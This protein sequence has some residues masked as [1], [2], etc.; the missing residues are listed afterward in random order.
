MATPPLRHPASPR[1]PSPP[2]VA[3]PGASA[4]V[5]TAHLSPQTLITLL[6]PPLLLSLREPF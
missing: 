5:S 3:V 6:F 4:S 2:Q 1:R